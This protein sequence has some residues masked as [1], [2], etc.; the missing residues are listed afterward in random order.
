MNLNLQGFFG[1]Y[2]TQKFIRYID[3]FVS[4]DCH[5]NTNLQKYDKISARESKNHFISNVFIHG[6]IE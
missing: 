4:M 5:N 2:G 3:K 6:H 1:L